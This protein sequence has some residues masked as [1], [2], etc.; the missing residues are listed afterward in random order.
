MIMVR[1]KG[2]FLQRPEESEGIS[3]V[4]LREETSR[5]CKCHR[6]G[7]S[8]VYSAMHKEAVRLEQSESEA[9]VGEEVSKEMAV[10]ITQRQRL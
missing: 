9:R 10:Q 3:C 8:L 2:D 7:I 1:D 6:A 4:D 5:W